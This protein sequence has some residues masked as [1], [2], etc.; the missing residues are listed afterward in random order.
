MNPIVDNLQLINNKPVIIK[1]LKIDDVTN[2][3]RLIRPEFKLLIYVVIVD[4]TSL[5]FIFTW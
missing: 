2:W 3:R 5:L 4:I 1:I